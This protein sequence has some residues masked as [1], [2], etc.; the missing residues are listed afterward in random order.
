MSRPDLADALKQRCLAVAHARTTTDRA[1]QLVGLGTALGRM[2][3][4]TLALRFLDEAVAL[5]PRPD[6]QAAAYSAAVRLHWDSGDLETARK[7][8]ASR[9]VP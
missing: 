4:D 2:G 7:V 9:P 6:A 1:W 8:D 5:E 3:E